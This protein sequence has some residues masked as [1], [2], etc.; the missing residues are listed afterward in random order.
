MSFNGFSIFSKG[1]S[2]G[3]FKKGVSHCL[4]GVLKWFERGV[5]KDI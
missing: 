1:V 2:K 4:K 5:K 3:G